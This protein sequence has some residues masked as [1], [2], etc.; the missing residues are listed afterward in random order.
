MEK[1]KPLVIMVSS[2]WGEQEIHEK[3]EMAQKHLENAITNKVHIYA[4]GDAIFNANYMISI[5]LKN[6]SWMEER[7]NTRH[8]EFNNSKNQAIEVSKL[9]SCISWRPLPDDMAHPR[10]PPHVYEAC[11]R[12]YSST[13]KEK[14]GELP[15][16]LGPELGD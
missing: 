8:K 11:M 3:V 14:S 16:S 13:R 1:G 2:T 12:Y 10:H 6:K 15:D 7:S 5:I 4:S 9:V